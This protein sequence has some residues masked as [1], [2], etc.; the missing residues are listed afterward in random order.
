MNLVTEWA[1]PSRSCR[2]FR[3][4]GGVGVAAGE[5]IGGGGTGG[6]VAC[7]FSPSGTF[8]LRVWFGRCRGD[9]DLVTTGRS[10]GV[11]PVAPLGISNGLPQTGQFARW[12]AARSGT[13]SFFPQLHAMVIDMASPTV[14]SRVKRRRIRLF[15]NIKSSI[16]RRRV[17]GAVRDKTWLN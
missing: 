5:A 4:G 11:V 14:Y 1:L 7:P 3:R 17:I 13:L 15:A 12:P 16:D 9:K 10:G 8:H 6:G 2:A